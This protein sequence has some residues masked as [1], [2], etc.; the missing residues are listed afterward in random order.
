[1]LEGVVRGL[2]VAPAGP[3]RVAA[4]GDQLAIWPVLRS[5]GD[6]AALGQP[7]V[8]PVS[9]ETTAVAWSPDARIVA[10]GTR[11]GEVRLFAAAT[12]S[13]LGTLAPHERKIER[14][15]FSPD[16]RIVV[17]ADRDC[18][19]IS[20]AATLTSFDELRPGIEVAGLCLTAD[21]ARLVLAGHAAAAG[22][23]GPAR[24][25][26]MELPSP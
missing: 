24:L 7:L 21:G 10:C 25:F 15:L 16:G 3:P 1:L 17:T 13:P 22:G 2:A 4:F 8:L 18:V 14:I 9:I 23:E 19:R 11:T 6:R 20:D 12:G 26:V 5:G